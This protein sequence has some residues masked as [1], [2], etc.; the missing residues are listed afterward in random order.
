MI[1]FLWAQFL[2][3]VR[4]TF[5]GHASKDS[6]WRRIR[7][8]LAIVFTEDGGQQFIG[9]LVRQVHAHHEQAAEAQLA[10]SNRAARRA[11]AARHKKARR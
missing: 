3:A 4:G 7:T 8:F 6:F 10:A 2:F 9:T 1:W 11:N 5:Q